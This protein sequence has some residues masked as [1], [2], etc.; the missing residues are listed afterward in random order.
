M[1]IARVNNLVNW[2]RGWWHRSGPTVSR[3]DRL[4]PIGPHAKGGPALR[5]LTYA[6]LC[7]THSL[8]KCGV[9]CQR[10]SKWTERYFNIFI[11]HNSFW[12]RNGVAIDFDVWSSLFNCS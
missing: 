2:D 5:L 8:F 4:L 12:N 3:L 11:H 6:S 10:K 7:E 9:L 1:K